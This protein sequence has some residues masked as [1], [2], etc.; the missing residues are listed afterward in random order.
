MKASI[1][2]PLL[3][4]PIL[5]FA[6][7]K[8]G[9]TD[10]Q[11]KE[12]YPSNTFKDGYDEDGVRYIETKMDGD[13]YYYFD[14]NEVSYICEQ[15]FFSDDKAEEVVMEY[16]RKYKILNQK[17]WQYEQDGMTIIIEMNYMHDDKSYVFTYFQK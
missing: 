15:V 11:I 7:A 14:D 8:I 4:A 1:I 3:I 13:F 2:L 16:D 6:Q 5:S 9:M 17:Q 10:S 12:S